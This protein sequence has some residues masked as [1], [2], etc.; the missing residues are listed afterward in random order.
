MIAQGDCADTLR[1]LGRFLEL[2]GASDITI[3]DRGDT[4]EAGWQDRSE[5][6]DR[7]LTTEEID[8]MRLT[9]RFFRGTSLSSPSFGYAEFLRTLGMELDQKGAEGIAVAETVDGFW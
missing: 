5:R 9:A 1:A 2:V 8:A 3:V 4:L 6:L 7:R